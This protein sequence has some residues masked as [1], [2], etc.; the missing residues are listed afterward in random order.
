MGTRSFAQVAPTSATI[1]LNA[2]IFGYGGHSLVTPHAALKQ[3]WW[4][5]ERIEAK[6]TR[7][8]IL[9]KLRGEERGFLNR[10]LTFGEDL[11]DDTYMDW[12]LEK[13][14]RLFLILTEIGVPDQIFGCIDD[15]WDDD[16]LPVSLEDVSSLELAYENDDALN[17]KFYD[18]QF[19]Y[20]LRELTQGSHID[21]GPKEHI[22]MEHVNSLPPAVSLQMWDRIHFPGRPDDVYMRRKYSLEDKEDGKDL[23]KAFMKDVRKA[24]SFAHEH[25]ASVW[26]SLYGGECSSRGI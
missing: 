16:D 6:V 1:A 21:Y 12:I 10:P 11:T 14:K 9:S 17:K 3:L 4:T 22:P 18:T 19:L 13:A 8:F 24:Q 2:Y 5:D 7:S 23:R 25:I 15:S 20:L 26:A